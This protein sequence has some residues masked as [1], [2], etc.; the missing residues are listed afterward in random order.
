[1]GARSSAPRS[2]LFCATGVFRSVG[3]IAAANQNVHAALQSLAADLGLAL[4][5]LVLTERDAAPGYRTFGGSKLGYAAA[6]LAALPRAHL[7]VFDHVRIALPFLA[8]PRPARPPVVICAH[9]SESWRRIRPLS[10]RAFTAAD[11]VLANSRY[12]LE[13]MEA[14]LGRFKGAA[15]P[16]GLPQQFV[17]ASAPTPPSDELLELR[18]ADGAARPIGDRMMLLVARMD[19]GER[20]KGHRELIAVWPA[21]RAGSPTAQLVL[22]GGGS[23]LAELR[24]RARETTAA[25]S[26]FLPGYVEKPVLEALY[27]KAYAFVMPSRQEGFGLAYLEAM[28]LSRPCV[29]CRDDGGAEV[30]VDGETGL[31]VDQ[32][33]D[34]GQLR[35]TLLRLLADP[36]LARRLGEAGWRRVTQHFTGAAHQARVADLIR[37]LL[38]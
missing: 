7:A 27:R 23:D 21:I 32:P 19:A 4:E 34:L 16:L 36:D 2:L 31:L 5:T 33:I 37:P 9:G 11:L 15:C 25:D 10:M 17:T 24:A 20:E 14:R 26:I 35:E 13:K 8:V 12:T 28:N 30:V 18:A 1:M 3:G 6:V 29:A 38:A 22:A